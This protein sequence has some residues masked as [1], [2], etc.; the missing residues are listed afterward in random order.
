MSEWMCQG[1][2][3]NL[4][5]STSWLIEQIGQD[6]VIHPICS[7]YALLLLSLGE[8]VKRGKET[9]MEMSHESRLSSRLFPGEAII[10]RNVRG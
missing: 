9:Q 4:T 8:H 10:K 1:A 3:T 7:E 5:Q 2:N 6:V